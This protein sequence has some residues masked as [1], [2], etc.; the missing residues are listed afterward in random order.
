M[1]VDG[2]EVA[3][4]VTPLVGNIIDVVSDSVFVVPRS[5]V[6][7]LGVSSMM[8]VELDEVVGGAI[9]VVAGR[10]QLPNLFFS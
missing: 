3:L 9:V 8:V 2:P 10:P 7:V 5:L 6:V 1:L 4:I